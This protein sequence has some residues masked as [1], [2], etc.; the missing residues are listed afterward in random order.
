MLLSETKPN[1]SFVK[2]LFVTKCLLGHDSCSWATY[3]QTDTF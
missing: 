1:L 3:D 2:N